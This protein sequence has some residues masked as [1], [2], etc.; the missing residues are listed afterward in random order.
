MGIIGQNSFAANVI[1]TLMRFFLS[2]AGRK[3]PIT[4]TLP[5]ILKENIDFRGRLYSIMVNC[6][7]KNSDIAA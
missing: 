1:R 3:L 5:A 2:V 7:R 6:H 4:D